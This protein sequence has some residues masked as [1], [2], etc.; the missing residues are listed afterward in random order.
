MGVSWWL[1]K[2]AE[3][4]EEHEERFFELCDRL[5]E[6]DQPDCD[7]D[8]DVVDRAINRPIGHVTW[9][10]TRWWDRRTLE[11]DQ[12]LPNEL[13]LRFTRICDPRAPKLRHG[14]VLLAAHLIALFRVD[15]EW[16]T[17]YMVPLF[18]WNRSEREARAAWE[19]FLWSPRL[20]RPLMGAAK[21][22][23]SRHRTTLREA[24]KARQ[25]IRAAAH[26]RRS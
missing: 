7:D 16:A 19:G 9:A 2:I 13:R 5:L 12:R 15:R 26:I 18:D 4:F 25:A 14:R 23:I 10:L 1:R 24:R 17:D 21:A 11:D 20:Y 3:T 6:L 8:E 22:S